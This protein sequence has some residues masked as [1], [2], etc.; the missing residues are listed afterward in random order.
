MGAARRQRE[1][2]G[3]LGVD[4][5]AVWANTQ[6]GSERIHENENT[7]TVEGAGPGAQGAR[8]SN[9]AAAGGGAGPKDEV[10]LRADGRGGF[11]YFDG[12]ETPGAAP[13]RRNRGG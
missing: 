3:K 2:G 13:E 6:Y 12:V 5:L 1:R 8:T 10:R 9:P 4:Y 7:G 11:G